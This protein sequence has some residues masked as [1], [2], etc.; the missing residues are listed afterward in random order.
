[1]PAVHRTVTPG[2]R[3]LRGAITLAAAC[4]AALPLAAQRATRHATVLF[5]AGHG[6]RFVIDRDEPLDLSALA[7]TL[8]HDGFDVRATTDPLTDRRL[9]G[10]DV[11]VISG[12]FQPLTGAESAAVLRFV[13]RGGRLCVMLH[14]APPLA[15]LLARMGV[16]T[17]NGVIRERR[18]LLDGQPLDFY[19]ASIDPHPLTRDLP[20]F[21]VYGAWALLAEAPGVAVVARTSRW[22]WVDLDGDSRL[23]P[24][25]ARQSLGVVVAGRYGRGSLAVFGDD[26]MF[27]NMFLRGENARLARNLARWLRTGATDTVA[28]ASR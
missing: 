12:A 1:M 24:A 6:Q 27:Q 10:V 19:V 22:S 5:D 26:A 9:A 18:N 4:C 14:V 8:R 20:R 7:G 17:S 23:G 15:P 16:V 25:D 2:N 28:T 21:A 11:L 13:A 3:L